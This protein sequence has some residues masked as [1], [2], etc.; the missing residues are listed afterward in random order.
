MAN[1]GNASSR[2]YPT[3]LE[4]P[5]ELS[6]Q[7]LEPLQHRLHTDLGKLHKAE[8]IRETEKRCEPQ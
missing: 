8:Q 7:S 2:A 3:R 6:P 1:E 4:L 5:Q